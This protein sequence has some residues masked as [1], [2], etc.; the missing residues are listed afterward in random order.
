MKFNHQM[1]Q[2]SSGGRVKGS[3]VTPKW[4]D[5]KS[6]SADVVR[7]PFLTPQIHPRLT[8]ARTH[9]QISWSGCKD[10]Q[11]S[12]DTWEA[13]TATGAMSYVRPLSTFLAIRYLTNIHCSGVHDLTP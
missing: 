4:I 11:T 8:Q 6:T 1:P 5:R 2:Y 13:G 7:A 10:S 3:Q 9:V 12:A